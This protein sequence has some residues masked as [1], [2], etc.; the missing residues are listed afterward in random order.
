[1]NW[2]S[3]CWDQ[4]PGGDALLPVLAQEPVGLSPSEHSTDLRGWVLSSKVTHLARTDLSEPSSASM[5][6][7]A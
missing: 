7:G 6:A 4:G 2:A 3:A 1:M 5:K